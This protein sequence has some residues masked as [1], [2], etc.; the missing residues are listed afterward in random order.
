[1]LKTELI[2]GFGTRNRSR[3]GPKTVKT[4]PKTD[5]GPV[6]AKTDPTLIIGPDVDS[7]VVVP[8]QNFEFR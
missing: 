3:S 4:G 2:I 7:H 8:I 1:M 6:F 5:A